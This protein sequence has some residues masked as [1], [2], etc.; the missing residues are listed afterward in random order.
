MKKIVFLFF[1]LL[2]SLRAEKV[3]FQSK[4]YL[5]ADLNTEQYILKKNIHSNYPIASLAKLFTALISKKYFLEKEYLKV[6]D[7]KLIYY[8]I[9]SKAGLKVGEEFR[10]RDLLSALL[11]PSGN[12][13]ARVLGHSLL[14]RGYPFED[15]SKKFTNEQKLF[16][17]KLYEPVGLSENTVSSA[18]DLW[19]VL[20]FLYS[21][22]LL[23]E[24]LNQD[25]ARILSKEKKPLVLKNRNPLPIYK[26]FSIYGKTG[27]TKKA[28]H[29]FA[30]FIRDRKNAER[31]YGII[32]LGAKDI[33]GELEEFLEY[34]LKNH[35]PK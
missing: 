22:P 4:A 7:I 26:Q 15:I 29:C 13:V 35:S 31:T 9:E 17:T 2:F 32:F 16:S 12:D 21:D 28:G 25:T 18:S 19:K 27:T 1:C 24:I 23:Y 14:E 6:P 33:R 34:L 3:S 11:L 10:F 5:L 8:P 20:L 30:G